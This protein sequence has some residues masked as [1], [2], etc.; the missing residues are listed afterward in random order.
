[1]NGGASLDIDAGG[2]LSGRVVADVKLPTQTLRATL[3]ISG[4]VQEPQIRK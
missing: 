3:N 2:G 4:K 1:M